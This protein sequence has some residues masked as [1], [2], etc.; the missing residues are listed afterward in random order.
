MKRGALTKKQRALIERWMSG[1]TEDWDML[2]CAITAA[3]ATIDA[4]REEIERLTD[5]MNA[6]RK[7]IEEKNFSQRVRIAALEAEVRSLREGD[8]EAAQV[9]EQIGV[10]LK[11]VPAKL[12]ALEAE[13][14]R[15]RHGAPIEGD[16]VCPDSLRAASLEAENAA[17]RRGGMR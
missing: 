14:D 12:A 16:F 2:R 4:Q 3:L 13:L 1:Q 11:D 6:Q 8:R 5:T 7:T 9:E 17:L 10:F 15:W